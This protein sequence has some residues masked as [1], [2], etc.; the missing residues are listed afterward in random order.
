MFMFYFL[1]NVCDLG[2]FINN[3]LE[4]KINNDLIRRYQERIGIIG[5]GTNYSTKYQT[6]FLL[7]LF[8]IFI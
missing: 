6:K 1:L 4:L 3:K 7:I 8:S 2:D 5:K